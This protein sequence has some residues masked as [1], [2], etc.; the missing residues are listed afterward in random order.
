MSFVNI[1]KVLWSHMQH[2]LRIIFIL[3]VLSSIYVLGTHFKL[4]DAYL[5]LFIQVCFWHISGS[6]D[7][8]KSFI[9]VFTSRVKSINLTLQK[10]AYNKRFYCLCS[11]KKYSWI[12]LT[13]MILYLLWIIHLIF[14]CPMQI[15]VNIRFV[16]W[17]L[18]LCLNWRVD[19]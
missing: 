7:P 19:F 8:K 4:N 1:Q 15:V 12:N 5:P 14:L 3:L 2:L 17:V 18:F 16:I 10:K 13:C 6:L 9:V 11:I